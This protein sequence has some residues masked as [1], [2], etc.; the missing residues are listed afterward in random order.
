MFFNFFNKEIV[1]G[2]YG[3]CK[4]RYNGKHSEGNRFISNNDL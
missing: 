4:Y 3:K 1:S 2:S